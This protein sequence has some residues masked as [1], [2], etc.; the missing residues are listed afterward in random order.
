MKQEKRCRGE[1]KPIEKVTDGGEKSKRK[2]MK[3]G[4][5]ALIKEWRVGVF[6]DQC[7]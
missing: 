4:K 1:I 7:S 3:K 6:T 2:K 5:A